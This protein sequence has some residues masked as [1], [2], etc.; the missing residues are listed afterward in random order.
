MLEAPKVESYLNN[1]IKKLGF[2]GF[3]MVEGV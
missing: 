2:K 3:T 1:I